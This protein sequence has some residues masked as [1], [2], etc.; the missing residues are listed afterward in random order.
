[1]PNSFW[2]C[3]ARN[4]LFLTFSRMCGH[5]TTKVTPLKWQIMQQN[6]KWK[7]IN[8]PTLNF[9]NGHL[10]SYTVLLLTSAYKTH[11]GYVIHPCCYCNFTFSKLWATHST[12]VSEVRALTKSWWVSCSCVDKCS[13]AESSS[14]SSLR[15]SKRRW[16]FSSVENNT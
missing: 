15:A 1:M 16:R 10:L 6:D 2:F 3:I 4:H 8:L 5:I 14:L 11:I 7:H 13:G 9:I 12:T